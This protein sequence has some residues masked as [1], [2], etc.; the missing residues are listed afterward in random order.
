MA[1]HLPFLVP[2]AG[3]PLFVFLPLPTALA[4][5]LPLTILSLAVAVPTLR[6]LYG[7]PT[8]GPEA[9]RGQEAVVVTAEGRSGLLSCDGELWRYTAPEPLAPGDRVTVVA[10]ED[11]TLVVRA[12]ARH[13]EGVR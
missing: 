13:P 2:L 11:L 7:P 6:A 9:M 1:C 8:T 4:L 10:V 12:T 3:L 5:Y